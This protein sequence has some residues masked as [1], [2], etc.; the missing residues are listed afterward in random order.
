MPERRP[1]SAAVAPPRRVGLPAT[2]ADR[3]AQ[4]LHAPLANQSFAPLPAATGA[5]PFRLATGALGLA[6]AERRVLHLVGD[7]GGVKDPNPQLRVAAAM[8]ADRAQSGAELL[9]H[10]GDV[11]YYNGDEREY[12]P[13]FYEPYAHYQAPIVA[14]PGNH[15]GDN[16]DDPAVPSLAAFVENLCS[17]EPHL[18][19]QAQETNRDT[20]DQ[21]NVYWT[22]TDELLT[23]VGLYTNV[24][25][26]GVVA[27][28]QVQWLVEE[29]RAAPA[30]SALIV[31]LHHPPYSCDA[32]HGGSAAMGQMLD[33]AFAAARRSPDLVLSGHVHDYQR[34]TRTITGAEVPY[35]VA[36]AGGYHNLHAIAPA[37]GGGPP[38]PPFRVRPDCV[39]EAYCDDEWGFLRLTVSAGAVVGEYVAV[40]R[41]GAVTRNKDSFTL[42]LSSRRVT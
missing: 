28:D 13:Q 5:P 19:P 35:I 17:A 14:I 25:E 3:Q 26:G 24:P 7:T 12:G 18:D 27:S 34:F 32:D 40:T 22:L 20:M 38:T 39:L 8:I 16:S 9:Y 15:D 23:I 33:G 42:D 31:A 1:T 4:K 10:L 21:P 37:P 41:D 30:T 11:I 6:V 2:T 36:G 29:L